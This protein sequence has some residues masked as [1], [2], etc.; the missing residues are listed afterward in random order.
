[1]PARFA[2]VDEYFEAVK[3]ARTDWPV[4]RTELDFQFEG[5]YTNT[6]RLK[7]ANRRC[8]NRLIEAEKFSS[9]ASRMASK[10]YP[11]SVLKSAWLDVMLNQFHDTIAGCGIPAVTEDALERYA[12]ATN[13]ALRHRDKALSVI[14]ERIN[15]RHAGVPVVI[16]NSLSWPRTGPVEVALPF[17]RIPGHIVMHAPNGK[18]IPAQIIGSEKVDDTFMVNCVFVAREVPGIGYKTYWAEVGES[19]TMKADPSPLHV[20]DWRIASNRF[21]INFDSATGDIVGIQDKNRDLPL[22]PKGRKAN[23]IQILED[24]GNSEGGLKWG[25]KKW[26]PDKLSKWNGWKVIEAGPV[27]ATVRIRNIWKMCNVAFDRYVT[28][29]AGMPL[30]YFYTHVEW[31]STNKMVKV[32]FPTKY[33]NAKPTFDNPYCTIVREADGQERPAMRWVELGDEN[34]GISVLNDCRYGHDVRDGVIRINV[35]RSPTH[36][37]YNTEC[38][39]QELSYA[40]YAHPGDWRQGRVMQYGY[41]FN[42]P[43]I[44]IVAESHEG[45][46]PSEGAWV[47]VDQPNVILTVMKEAEDSQDLIVRVYEFA[48]QKCSARLQ[49]NHLAVTKANMTNMLEKP[50]ADL[51]VKPVSSNTSYVDVPVGSYEIVTVDLK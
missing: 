31:N 20:E 1:V 34:S 4:L 5:N 32:A 27:R 48:G 9:I 40:L 38:G 44:G 22:V 30:I 37:A 3:N 16:F 24:L 42:N 45:N 33:R 19:D 6:A 46:L 7:A 51:S 28:V 23:E 43:L 36:P 2:R 49:L 17:D 25:D 18:K 13:T 50:S 41:E 39:H 26:S 29:Y 8:E 10:A 47:S 14:C 15:T 11:K 12:K 35:L 21:E